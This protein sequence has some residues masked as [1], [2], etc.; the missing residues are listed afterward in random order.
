MPTRSNVPEASWQASTNP[1]GF[2]RALEGRSDV[3]VRT[4]CWSFA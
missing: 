3:D 2:G 4:D 1:D